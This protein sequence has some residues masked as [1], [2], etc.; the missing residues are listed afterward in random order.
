MVSRRVLPLLAILSLTLSCERSY[1]LEYV[2]PDGFSGILKLRAEARNGIKL[3]ETDGQIVLTFPQSGTLDVKGK[4]PTL[5]WHKPTARFADGAGIPIAGS[6]QGKVADD[7]VA[8]RGL[9]IKNNNTESWYLIGTARELP[10][11][12]EQFDGFRVPER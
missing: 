7:V 12:M 9:G 8:L 5:E 11:A 2:V 10:K 6:S 4:L 1:T 3:V